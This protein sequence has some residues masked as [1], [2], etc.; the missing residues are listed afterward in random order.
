MKG[1]L[2]RTAARQGAPTGTE[3]TEGKVK[4]HEVCGQEI[5]HVH[6]PLDEVGLSPSTQLK[7]GSPVSS[8]NIDPMSQD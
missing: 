5:H 2:R 7:R 3:A 1:R 4:G 8:E 6:L